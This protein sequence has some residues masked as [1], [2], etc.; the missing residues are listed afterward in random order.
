MAGSG[1]AMT[2][3]DYIFFGN[4]FYNGIKCNL[5]LMTFVLFFFL[6]FFLIRFV[7]FKGMDKTK[8]RGWAHRSV[9]PSLIHIV[10][11]MVN[12]V[13]V[14]ERS[15]IRTKYDW[16]YPRNEWGPHCKPNENETIIF[17]TKESHQYLANAI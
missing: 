10:F 2:R 5:E 16:P 11:V 6:S 14:V 3:T 13:D 12:I 15:H 7:T 17:W 1:P 8:F 4:R 9:N